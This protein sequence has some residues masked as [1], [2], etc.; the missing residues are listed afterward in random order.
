MHPGAVYGLAAAQAHV[1]SFVVF[2]LEALMSR[3]LHLSEPY[4]SM[5]TQDS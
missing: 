5:P 4:H 2:R 3:F 1:Y